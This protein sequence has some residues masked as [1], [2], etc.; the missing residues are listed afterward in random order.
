MNLWHATSPT[1]W[2]GRNDLSEADNALRLFQ[3]VKLSPYFTPEEFPHAIALLGFECDE[4]VKL[5]QGRPGANQGPDY[6][7]KALANMA[8]HKG[9]DRLVDL[10]SIRANPNQL[11]EAQQALADAITQCQ[12]QNV[13]TLVLG[14]GHETAFAHGVGI[15]DAF[16]HQ[17]IGIIN[18]DAHLD[19][20]RS[21]QP[22]SGTPFRQLAE[23]C[24]QHQRQF[25]YTCVGASLAS[26][27][28]ALVDEA[29]RLNVTIIWDNQCSETMLDKVQRQIQ[30][31]LQQVDLI[32]MTI[33]L[34][35]LPAYQMPA[36]SA[37]AALG[38]PLERLL[39]LI[40]PICQSGKLQAADL[41][42][43][44]PT[45]DIQGIGGKAAARLAWQ[46]AHWWY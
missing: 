20:R 3:T 29:N 42:E 1:I 25:H 22:T 36:V 30:D 12:H 17:R 31:T 32:Y 27:T 21:P 2:Q 14:G 41:V 16:P 19:L 11:S 26:N 38:L 9:H 44:N 43:L 8:S 40:Q 46:L 24:Q 33:D 13:R 39:Q 6:L 15:Y 37:P 23:Y 10:G 7:R 4:G 5:N 28:Q 35:V 45:F 34:D 18:F